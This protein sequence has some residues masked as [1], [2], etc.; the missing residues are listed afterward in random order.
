M[1]YKQFTDD[2]VLTEADMDRFWIQQHSVI[3]TADQQVVSSTVLVPDD[4]LAVP[5]LANQDYWL[6][7]FLI[8]DAIQSTDLKLGWSYPAGT[9]LD[10]S[11]G[12]LRLGATSTVDFV[13]RTYLDETGFPTIGGPAAAA[14]SI[15][16]VMGEGVVVSSATAGE[17][18]LRFS[19]NTNTA[20]PTIL[21]ANSLL[22]LQKLTE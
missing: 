6:E 15:A 4:E 17:L 22:I 10:W 5:I 12:G 16:V 13:S 19:Q 8:Y 1:P 11:H 20:T 9:T 7:V 3:K 2:E 18:R 14:P 21:K